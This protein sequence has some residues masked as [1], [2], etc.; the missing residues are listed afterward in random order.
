MRLLNEVGRAVVFTHS[1]DDY[2]L[3][4][5]QTSQAGPG[6]DVRGPD[7]EL[8]RTAGAASRPPLDHIP[9]LYYCDPLEGKDAFGRPIPAGFRIDITAVIEDKARMLACHASQ[10][11]GCGSTTGWTT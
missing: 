9:H 4:H 5:E 11:A 1:P 8:P 7:P 6:G 10:R 2:H 3:D